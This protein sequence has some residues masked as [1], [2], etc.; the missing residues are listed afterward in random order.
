MYKSVDIGK[1]I[2]TQRELLGITREELAEKIGIT[3]R[4]CYDLELGLKGMSVQT[5]YKLVETLHVSSDYLLFGEQK[6]EQG[7]AAGISLL[8]ACPVDKRQFLNKIIS[9]YLQALKP[10]MEEEDI[11]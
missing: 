1:R 7:V 5:L 4:F 6:E 11:V 2:K 3:P 10:S 9:T 8:K